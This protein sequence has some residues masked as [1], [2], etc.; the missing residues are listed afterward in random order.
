MID[1]DGHWVVN[2]QRYWLNQIQQQYN[3]QKALI[4]LASESMFCGSSRLDHRDAN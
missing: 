2:W 1:L 4:T 3:E